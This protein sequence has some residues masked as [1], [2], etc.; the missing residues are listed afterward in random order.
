M[1]L[2]KYNSTGDGY[3]IMRFFG[4]SK[5]S[6]VTGT[7]KNIVRLSFLNQKK[8]LDQN[9]FLNHNLISRLDQIV[10]KKFFWRKLDQ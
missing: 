1:F 3:P 5:L 10:S 9:F 4:R 8:K 6:Y 7:P 2:Q